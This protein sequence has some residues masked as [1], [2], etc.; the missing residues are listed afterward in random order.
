M[1]LYLNGKPILALGNETA[2]ELKAIFMRQAL[3]LGSD[4]KRYFRVGHADFRIFGHS[5]MT[6]QL[7][8]AGR[9]S[10]S[11]QQRQVS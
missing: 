5:L 11:S 8:F 2:T 4:G 10:T 6:S 3:R 1:S 9:T 7:A